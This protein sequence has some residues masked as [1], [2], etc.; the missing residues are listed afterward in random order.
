ML[1]VF[2]LPR[3]GHMQLAITRLNDRRIRVFTWFGLEYD[4]VAPL[5]QVVRERQIER[6]AAAGCVVI[7]QS[8]RTV[9]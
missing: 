9:L 5:S 1:H 8:V 6:T 2:T 7:D 4:T 3:V